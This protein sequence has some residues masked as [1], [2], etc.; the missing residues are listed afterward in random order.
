M[1]V[2]QLCGPF[3]TVLDVLRTQTKS[4]LLSPGFFGQL[5][6]TA[7]VILAGRHDRA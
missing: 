6:L 1:R 4:N 7:K 3:G 2:V 5:I